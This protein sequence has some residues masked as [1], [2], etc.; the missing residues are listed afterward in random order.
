MTKL[1]KFATHQGMHFAFA[2]CCC[3]AC[4]KPWQPVTISETPVNLT[5]INSPYDDY[6]SDSPTVGETGP[7]CFSSNRNSEGE[8]FDIVYKLIDITASRENGNL[9]VSENNHPLEGINIQNANLNEAIFKINH[10]GDELGP[11][12]VPMGLRETGSSNST[13]SYESY[14]FLFATNEGGNLDIGFL[15]NTDAET[16]TTPKSVSFLNSE[17]DDAYPSLNQESNTLY[18]CSDRDGQFDIY[19]TQLN[20][21]A[22]IIQNLDDTSP[23]EVVKD[24]DL[25]SAFDDK[26]PY[27][28]NDVIIFTSN[29]PGGFGG[30]DLYYSIFTAGKWSAPRNF[31]NKINTQY[32]EYRPIIKQMGLD[33]ANDMMIFSSNR[34]GGNGGFDLYYVGISLPELK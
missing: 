9:K 18:F 21:A 28:A 32:D 20:D 16:Y 13:D 12:L 7:L 34:P 15:H 26:C 33:F 6:N 31:G 2:A 19:Y 29:R 5:E 30:F 3:L 11:Y 22:T 24:S 23:H 8:N 4:D 25:S 14:V 10:Q 17:Q 27:I 1:L